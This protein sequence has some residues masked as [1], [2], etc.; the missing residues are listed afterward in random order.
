MSGG[1]PL[2]YIQ[3]VGEHR[4]HPGELESVLHPLAVPAKLQMFV[5]TLHLIKV[6]G[7]RAKKL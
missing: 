7:T 2:D 5:P 1:L 6:I 4:E 3:D